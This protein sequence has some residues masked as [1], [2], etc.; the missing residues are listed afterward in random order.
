LVVAV[1][2]GVQVIEAQVETPQHF[3]LSLL[4]VAVEVEVPTT[5]IHLV[6]VVVV[7]TLNILQEAQ[8]TLAD[9]IL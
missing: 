1:Q 4:Q 9:M 7:E 3:L 5:L 2:V 8:V 6:V